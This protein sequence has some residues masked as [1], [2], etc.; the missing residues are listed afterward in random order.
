MPV[1]LLSTFV[2]GKVVGHAEHNEKVYSE[3]SNDNEKE[4]RRRR[5]VAFAATAV[6]E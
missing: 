5:Y 4:Q 3:L 6:A 2:P 1:L